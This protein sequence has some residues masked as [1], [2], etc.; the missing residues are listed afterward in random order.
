MENARPVDFTYN[1]AEGLLQKLD[2][3]EMAACIMER[4]LDIL[5]KN[6]KENK[7]RNMEKSSETEKQQQ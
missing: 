6:K 4:L 7:G 3:E 1:V 2:L 5:R